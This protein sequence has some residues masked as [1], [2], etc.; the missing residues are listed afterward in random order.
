MEEIFEELQ[1]KNFTV[2]E[3]VADQ[4]WWKKYLTSCNGRST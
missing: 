3:D 4:L 2:M 1:W